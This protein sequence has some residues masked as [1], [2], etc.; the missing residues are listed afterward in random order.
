MGEKGDIIQQPILLLNAGDEANQE[1]IEGTER[2]KEVQRRFDKLKELGENYKGR[3]G[4]GPEDIIT[5]GDIV[6]FIRETYAQEELL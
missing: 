1:G 4:K 2:A 6:R 3:T 5:V